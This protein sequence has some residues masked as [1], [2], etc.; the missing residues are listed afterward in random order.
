MV[1]M[2]ALIRKDMHMKIGDVAPI[3][4]IYQGIVHDILYSKYGYRKFQFDESL[5]NSLVIPS[6]S[7]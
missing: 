2:I 6:C 5:D 3:L 1:L 7:E 4:E